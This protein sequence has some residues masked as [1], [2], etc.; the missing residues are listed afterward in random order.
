MIWL[1]IFSI[2]KIISSITTAEVSVEEATANSK[3][4]IKLKHKITEVVGINSE[5]HLFPAFGKDYTFS[6]NTIYLN[7]RRPSQ[8]QIDKLIYRVTYKHKKFY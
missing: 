3:Y 8:D 2:Y 6:G 4:Q 1:A 5:E 7:A